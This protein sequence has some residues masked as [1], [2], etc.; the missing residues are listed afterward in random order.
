MSGSS[1]RRV[2]LSLALSFLLHA[3]SSFHAPA[4]PPP[5]RR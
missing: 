4:P 3:A 2:L 5:A 1:F